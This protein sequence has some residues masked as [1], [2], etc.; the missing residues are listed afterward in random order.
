MGVYPLVTKEDVI[1]Q[2][3][4]D[5]ETNA[6]EKPLAFATVY[7]IDAKLW[8]LLNLLETYLEEAPPFATLQKLYS[9]ENLTTPEHISWYRMYILQGKLKDC[10]RILSNIQ[11]RYQH[12]ILEQKHAVV[13]NITEDVSSNVELMLLQRLVRPEGLY[14]IL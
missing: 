12:S 13:T 10:C 1:Q 9:N 3:L 2:T 4:A 8:N 5:I 11:L 6:H 14:F 7:H